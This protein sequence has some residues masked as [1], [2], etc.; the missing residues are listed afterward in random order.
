LGRLIILAVRGFKN[1]EKRKVIKREKKEV[2]I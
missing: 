1:K 2:R